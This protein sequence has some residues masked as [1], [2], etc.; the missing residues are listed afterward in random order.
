MLVAVIAWGLAAGSSSSYAGH[1]FDRALGTVA[2]ERT[3]R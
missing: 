3:T 2:V 1:G